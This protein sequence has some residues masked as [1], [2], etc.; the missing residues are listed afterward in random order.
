M[1]GQPYWEDATSAR[2][3]FEYVAENSELYKVLLGEQGLGHVMHRILHYMAAFDEATLARFVPPDTEPLMPIHH[4][5][6]TDSGCLFCISQMV[7]RRRYALLSCRDG[8][9]AAPNVWLLVCVALFKVCQLRS[10]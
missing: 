6:P 5:S 4:F 2:I 10:A 8:R 3:V 1:G 9:D 7:V